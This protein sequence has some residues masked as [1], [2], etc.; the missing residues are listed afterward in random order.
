MKVVSKTKAISRTARL[1]RAVPFLD[2]IA[3]G[4]DVMTFIDESREAELIKKTNKLR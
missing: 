2:V 1:M 3:F 4:M